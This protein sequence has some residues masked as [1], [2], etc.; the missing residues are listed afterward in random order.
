MS[1][2]MV[3]NGL[4]ETPQWVSKQGYLFRKSAKAGKGWKC[5]WFVLDIEGVLHW[6]KNQKVF[7][8]SSVNEENK[9]QRQNTTETKTKTQKNKKQNKRVLT[10]FPKG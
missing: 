6:W 4:P 5:M 10:L 9:K 3:A 8:A 7:S 1:E 2:V